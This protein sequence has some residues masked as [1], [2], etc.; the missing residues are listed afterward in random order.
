MGAG[1]GQ[2][3]DSSPPA[4]AG[5]VSPLAGAPGGAELRFACLPARPPARRETAEFRARVSRPTAHAAAAAAPPPPEPNR[6]R[7]VLMLLPPGLARLLLLGLPCPPAR[8]LARRPADKRGEKEVRAFPSPYW[9]W[10]TWQ[11]DGVCVGFMAGLRSLWAAPLASQVLQ[12]GENSGGRD[13]P[14]SLAPVCP[15]RPSAKRRSRGILS[16][17][18]AT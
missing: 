3:A 6:P 7:R 10:A 16:G 4:G 15:P 2:L 18:Y 11:G 13:P 12:R 1:R 5:L 17:R 8:S 9:T 14:G